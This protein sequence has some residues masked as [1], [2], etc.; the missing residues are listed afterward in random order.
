MNIA[1]PRGRGGGCGGGWRRGRGKSH[2]WW[3]QAITGG[4]RLS[5]IN[6]EVWGRRRKVVW[7]SVRLLWLC[8]VR[9]PFRGGGCRRD[10]GGGGGGCRRGRSRRCRKWSRYYFWSEWSRVCRCGWW[11]LIIGRPERGCARRRSWKIY[12]CGS[13][14]IEAGSGNFIIGC[15][16]RDFV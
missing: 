14:L 5:A 15:Q 4:H 11:W 12:K 7:T 10:S 8:P 2:C 3:W 6:V 9:R 1:V 16:P 13:E